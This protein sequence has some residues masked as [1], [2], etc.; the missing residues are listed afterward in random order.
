MIERVKELGME[1]VALTDHGTMS[2]AIELYKEAK[3]QGIKPLIGIETYVSA[4]NHTD[5]ILLK[6]KIIII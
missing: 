6:I 5:K 1:A 3:A 4:R 2:G